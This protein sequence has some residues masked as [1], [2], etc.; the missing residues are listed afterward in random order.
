ADLVPLARAARDPD[1]AIT[2]Y[3]EDAIESLGRVKMD[4]L[5]SRALTTLVDT[6]Q[7]SP[8]VR[9]RGSGISERSDAAGGPIPTPASGYPRSLTPMESLETI[10]FDD[11]RTYKMM[12]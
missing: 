8:G 3:E 6:V 7:A 12:A 2:Q 4:L 11:E 5:G 1:M 9:D 10:P